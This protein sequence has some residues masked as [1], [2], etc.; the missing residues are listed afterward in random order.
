MQHR[1]FRRQISLSFDL[2]ISS[3]WS[4]LSTGRWSS[5]GIFFIRL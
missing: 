2:Q 3:W 4:R 1:P 5:Y